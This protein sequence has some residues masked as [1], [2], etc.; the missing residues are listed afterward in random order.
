M[1]NSNKSNAHNKTW[2][3]VDKRSPEQRL[4]IAVLSAAA[5]DAIS[6]KWWTCD[7]QFRHKHKRS[8][9][10]DYFLTPSRSFFQIC[11]WAGLDPEYVK[12][13]MEKAICS[14]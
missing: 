10:Q 13:K 9:D 11:H 12:R 3:T 5:E 1:A 8:A 2:E 4:W 14:K 7:G 6:D